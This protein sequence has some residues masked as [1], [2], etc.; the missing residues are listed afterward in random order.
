MKMFSHFNFRMWNLAMFIDIVKK[1]QKIGKTNQINSFHR[2]I[3]RLVDFDLTDSNVSCTSVSII[4]N[5]LT[6]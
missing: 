3:Y 1:L 2:Y 5:G 4:S 6:G